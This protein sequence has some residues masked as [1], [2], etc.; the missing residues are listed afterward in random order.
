MRESKQ[1][2][3]GLDAL[4]FEDGNGVLVVGCGGY[5]LRSIPIITQMDGQSA[6]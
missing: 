2:S 5:C 6:G 3:A 1:N 4:H